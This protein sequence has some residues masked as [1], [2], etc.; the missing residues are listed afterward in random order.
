MEFDV[1]R[2]HFK[3]NTERMQLIRATHESKVKEIRET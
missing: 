2:K 1:L 3:E